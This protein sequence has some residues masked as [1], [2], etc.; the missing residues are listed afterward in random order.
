[1]ARLNEIIWFDNAIANPKRATDE[2]IIAVEQI[3]GVKLPKD[4]VA[5]AREHQGQSLQPNGLDFNEDGNGLG[6]LL[7]FE[8]DDERR[9]DSLAYYPAS[10][11][12]YDALP[13]AVP[14]SYDGGGNYFA[15]D[16]GQDSKNPPIVFWDH[17]TGS[18]D[19]VAKSFT[20]LVSMLT[21]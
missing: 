13:N 4:Y 21:E 16:Y 9:Q 12:L 20:D 7:H 17:E 6:F 11:G 14:F 15:F 1:M 3:L 19:F 18:V 8:L 5:I 10:P 2:Q